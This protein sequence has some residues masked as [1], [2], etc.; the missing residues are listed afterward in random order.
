MGSQAATP[1]PRPPLNLCKRL[2]SSGRRNQSGPPGNNRSCCRP[3]APEPI[4]SAHRRLADPKA[5]AASPPCGAST[6]H[7][8]CDL[9][10]DLVFVDVVFQSIC[11][12]SST[13]HGDRADCRHKR[14]AVPAAGRAAAR[15]A[16]E[17][18]L[19]LRAE[20][21]HVVGQLTHLGVHHGLHEVCTDGAPRRPR[22]GPGGAAAAAAGTRCGA[23]HAADAGGSG[24]TQ[25][26]RCRPTAL[27]GAALRRRRCHLRRKRHDEGEHVGGLQVVGSRRGVCDRDLQGLRQRAGFDRAWG[28]GTMWRQADVALPEQCRRSRCRGE[29]TDGDAGREGPSP[30]ARG[31]PRG[32]CQIHQQ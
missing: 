12:D 2:D 7:V 18:D 31:R 26:R 9:S 29:G 1:S 16:V 10:L 19:D 5:R 11:L 27:S 24:G 17:A 30:C 6:G 21:A 14:A 28:N 25:A 23:A 3:S 15:R 20:A 13:C 32:H 4:C 22:G 8:G